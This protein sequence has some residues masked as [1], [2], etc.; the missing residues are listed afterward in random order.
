MRIACVHLPSFALQVQVRLAPHRAGTA[1]AVTDAPA[2]S[3]RPKILVCSRRA[4]ELGVR[5]GMS[6]TQ[7]RALAPECEVLPGDPARCRR[8]LEALAEALMPLSV[9]VDAGE[10]EAPHQAIYLRVPRSR[11]GDVYA[12]RLLEVI[13]RHGY[14]ARVGVADDRFTAWAAAA[15][16]PREGRL[17]PPAHTVVPRGAAA[18]FLAP[19]SLDLLPLADD[20]RHMLTSLGVRTLGDFAALPPPSVGRRWSRDGV[21]FQKLAAGDG[22]TVLRPFSP[23]DEVVETVDLEDEV[24]E[25]EPLS[26]LLRPLADRVADRLRGRNAAVG[27][28]A[29]RLRGRGDEHTEIVLE[30]SRP[31]ASGRALVELARASLADRALAHPVVAVEL[32]VTDEAEPELEELD[33]FDARDGKTGPEAVDVAIARLEALLGADAASAAEL[34]DS[35]RPESAFRLVPFAPPVRTRKATRKGRPRSARRSRCPQPALPLVMNGLTGA[36][37]LL[38][39]PRPQPRDLAAIDVDGA[40]AAVVETRGPTRVDTEW[41][42]SEPVAR[43]YYEVET[44]DGGRYWVY[45]D[46]SGG[47]Y[48]HGIFD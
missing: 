1:F 35:H 5:P 11:R 23:R 22:P 36:L 33:L 3:A 27:R 24:S 8:S 39:P 10:G 26:F 42:T 15:A 7:A 44:E 28:A 9:T 29:L 19:L 25:L 32:A 4:W 13:G 17:F 45:R 46:P 2:G 38:E 30:P 37:R 41:W 12:A 40:R 18:V 48:L 21:D 34:V 31:T 6:A 14:R 47:Y 16:P 20:V 43:D